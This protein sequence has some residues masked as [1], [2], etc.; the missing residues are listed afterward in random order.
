MYRNLCAL[1]LKNLWCPVLLSN[2]IF[3]SAKVEGIIDTKEEKGRY[4]H[5]RASYFGPLETEM[6][7]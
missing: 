3:S 5:P 4:F 2:Y 1:W 6:V 7:Q